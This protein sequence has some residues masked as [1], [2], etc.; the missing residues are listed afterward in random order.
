M[1]ET[2]NERFVY[3]RNYEEKSI[4]L[5]KKKLHWLRWDKIKNIKEPNEGYRKYLKVFSWIYGNF[6]PKIELE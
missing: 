5:L 2:Y 1:V 3:K 6:S 4:I